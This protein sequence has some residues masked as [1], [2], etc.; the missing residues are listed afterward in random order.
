MMVKL[1]TV[2]F[3][4]GLQ[5]SAFAQPGSPDVNALAAPFKHQ[6]KAKVM[7][8]GTFHFNDGGNDAYKPKYSVNIKSPERQAEV[9]ELVQLL[10]KFKPTRVAIESMPQRQRFHDSLY[11]EFINKRYEPGENE[12][13]Q[14]CY[15]LAAMMGHKKLYNI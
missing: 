2:I 4:L 9:K 1:Y 14:L 10:A 13:F 3:F 6:K 8:L 7:I 11:T 5:S 12:I 15:R